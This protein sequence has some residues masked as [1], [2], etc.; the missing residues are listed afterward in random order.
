MEDWKA[1]AWILPL[2]FE[3][4]CLFVFF[5]LQLSSLFRKN[6][7]D[8]AENVMRNCTVLIQG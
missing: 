4:Y 3:S 2:K 7:Q 8:L 1:Q 6:K 5:Y